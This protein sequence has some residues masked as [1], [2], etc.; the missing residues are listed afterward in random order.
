MRRFLRGVSLFIFLFSLTLSLLPTPTHAALVPC[1]RQTGTP[2]EM[3][4]CTLCHLVVGGHG[5]IDY[6]LKLMTVLALTVIVAMALLYIVSTGNDSLMGTAK[7]GIKASLIGFALM[8]GAFLLVT[9]TLR[10]LSA[11]IPGLTVS[12]GG[13][14]F[15]CSTVSSASTGTPS[16]VTPAFIPAAPGATGTEPLAVAEENGTPLLNPSLPAPGAPTSTASSTNSTTLS[17]TAVPGATGYEIER[18]AGA[19]CSTF[20][21]LG[22]TLLTSYLDSLLSSNQSYTYRVRTVSRDGVSGWSTPTTLTT[23]TTNLAPGQPVLTASNGSVTLSWTPPSG[24]PPTSYVIERCTGTSCSSFTRIG[25]STTPS[26]TDTNLA[27]GTSYSYRIQGSNS[28]L[29]SSI[30]SITTPASSSATGSTGQSCTSGFNCSDGVSGENTGSNSCAIPSG[31]ADPAKD[32]GLWTGTWRPSGAG[33]LYVVDQSGPLGAGGLTTFPGCV[34]Q[35][36]SGPSWPCYG[37]GNLPGFLPPAPGETWSIRYAAKSNDPGYFQIGDGSGGGFLPTSM[38]FSLSTK[39]GDFSSS[40]DPACTAGSTNGPYGGMLFTGDTMAKYNKPGCQ[41]TAG[42]L[43]Y[44]NIKYLGT[45]PTPEQCR[46]A[47]IES[48]NLSGTSAK[49]QVC[50]SGSGSSSGVCSAGAAGDPGFGS[51]TWRPSGTTNL[52]VV[53]QS[54]TPNGAGGF[55]AFPGCVNGG[56]PSFD[57]PSTGPGGFTMDTGH[58]AAIRFIAGTQSTAQNFT[59]MA[60]TGSGIPSAVTMTLSTKPG[61]FASSLPAACKVTAPQGSSNV[62]ITVGSNYCSVIPGSMYYLNVRTDSTCSGGTCRFYLQEPAS[63]QGT[64]ISCGTSSSGSTTTPSPTP[65]PTPTP[66]P[67]TPPFPWTI[68]GVVYTSLSAVQ[69][70]YSPSC[71]NVNGVRVLSGFG[72]CVSGTAP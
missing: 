5:V 64:G 69:A 49:A 52:W 48:V 12:P 32:P 63:M 68:Q 51:G 17:W 25:T 28:S 30:A 26:Y 27:P 62:K 33:K 45:C 20:T 39:P 11:Q 7:G 14:S 23:S 38:K 60:G 10:V 15:S 24:T 1:G 47:V 8:L 34:N 71:V 18:C 36:N 41:L 53:D 58:V 55:T 35:A 72:P 40:L 37:W 56:F 16:V 46:L 59:L 66:V 67:T 61:D 9:T 65:T 2:E 31:A 70:A 22:A 50:A 13:F 6:G 29:F 4:P 21:S 19:S 54:G 3:A 44:L 43:Y 42:T 57:C